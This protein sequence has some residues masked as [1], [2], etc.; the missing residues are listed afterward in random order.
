MIIIW[1]IERNFLIFWDFNNLRIFNNILCNN[2]YLSNHFN[3]N[4]NNFTS[5]RSN[6]NE[7]SKNI[8]SRYVKENKNLLTL[9]DGNN[10]NEKELKQYSLTINKKNKTLSYKIKEF[11]KQYIVSNHFNPENGKFMRIKKN[12]DS[13]NSNIYKKTR[14]LFDLMLLP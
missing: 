4:N 3:S 6:L 10:E 2:Y 9:F 11:S 13:I 8:N 5:F 12:S 1:K 14:K 7:L